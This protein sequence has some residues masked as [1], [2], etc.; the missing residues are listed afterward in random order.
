MAQANIK[1]TNRYASSLIILHKVQIKLACP[2]SQEIPR[3]LWNMKVHCRVQRSL[4]M[5]FSRSQLELFTASL[6][7]FYA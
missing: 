1:H 3:L 6:I 4:S 7:S 2:A 5:K